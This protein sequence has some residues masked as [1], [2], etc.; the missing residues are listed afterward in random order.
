[1]A[2]VV[3]PTFL[4][5]G[6]GKSGTSWIARNL[7][8]HRD[9]FIPH[10][11]E[12]AF[13][14]TYPNIGV[15]SWGMWFYKK[16]FGDYRGEQHIGEASTVYMYDPSSPALIYRHIPEVQLIFV[17]RNPIDRVYANYWQEI[18]AGKKMDNF[19]DML[20]RGH[21]RMEEMIEVSRYDKHIR[22]YLE[23]F[24]S[25]HMLV[26]LYDDLVADARAF[27][28]KI[29][30]F[31]DL[32]PAE[33][34]MVSKSR[35]NPSAMPRFCSVARILRNGKL[36]RITKAVMPGVAGRTLKRGLELARSLNERPLQY[37][38]LDEESRDILAGRLGKSVELVQSML[39]RDLSH[40]FSG[41]VGTAVND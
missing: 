14:S 39:G 40:W 20:K 19:G 4:I 37:P 23:F 13:F 10:A 16:N 38:V 8:Y 17:L 29:F 3:L 34:E 21:P 30:G 22:R 12:P 31:L 6:A 32:D 5:P 35:V 33:S 24:P 25:N 1:V 7:S 2:E 11:K 9:V 41:D 18:K 26:L 36:L 15:Y 28:E 27:M